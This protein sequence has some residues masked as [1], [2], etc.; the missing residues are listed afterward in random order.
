[1][2]ELISDIVF[3]IC[4]KKFFSFWL[5]VPICSH[6][7]FFF[8]FSPNRTVHYNILELLLDN[9]NMWIISRSGFID[10]FLF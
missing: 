9:F 8:F 1:M 5:N 6:K 10:H 3:F 2:N 4:L 7:W